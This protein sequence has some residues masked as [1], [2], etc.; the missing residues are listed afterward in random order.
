MAGPDQAPFRA[1]STVRLSSW[2]GVVAAAQFAVLAA[3]STRYGF[4]RDEM[5]FIV[6]GSH[7]AFGYPDQPPLVPLLSWLMH[8]LAPGSLL[9]LRL[10]S[11]LAA[12]ATTILAALVAREVG[13]RRRAQVIAAGCTASSGF[14]LAVGHFVTTTT[15][16][17]LSTTALCWLIVRAL[18]R[19]SAR[20]MLAAGIIV[21]LG[22]EAKPQVGFVAF[23][24]VGVLL[25]L[26]PRDLL[27]SWWTVG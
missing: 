4:H 24:V 10:P 5:Y 3:T 23:V 9:V 14:A 16:D 25:V 15:F 27:R 17:L 22:V 12:G 11:A 7:P 2:V 6:A 13:G 1:R 8:E 21:G 19:R 18:M 20:P 26:G